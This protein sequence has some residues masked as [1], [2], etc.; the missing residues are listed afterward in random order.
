MN[1]KVA[2]SLIILL[3]ITS[4]VSSQ[5]APPKV[6][7]SPAAT[8]TATTT[9]VLTQAAPTPTSP[10]IILRAYDPDEWRQLYNKSSVWKIQL[11][12]QQRIWALMDKGIVAFYNGDHWQYFSGKDYGFEEFPS[13]MVVAPDDT[14]WIVGQHGLS[15]YK[16]GQWYVTSLPYPNE[17]ATPRLA[18]DPSGVIW[19]ATPQCYCGDSIKK[20]NGSTWDDLWLWKPD[21]MHEASQLLFAPGRTLWAAFIFPGSIGQYDGKTWKIYSGTDLW[22]SEPYTGIQ[23]ASDSVGDIFGIYDEQEWIV[24][25]DRDGSISKIPFDYA[26]LILNPVMLRLF[27]DNQGTIWVNACLRDNQNDCLAYYKDDQWVSYVNFPYSEVT[28][29]TELTDGTFLVATV[30]GLYQFKPNE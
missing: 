4:C 18:V 6:V 26:D 29:M 11:D 9:Q 27:V 25:I 24:R 12:S 5:A 3:S 16:E 7:N 14:V 17:T 30:Y 8:E 2:L 19:V 23:I 21:L 20:F 22:S 28:D 10:G 15:H 13:D 1:K